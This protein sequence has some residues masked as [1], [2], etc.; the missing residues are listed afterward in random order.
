MD[1]RKIK[2]VVIVNDFNYVQGGASKVAIDTAKILKEQGIKVFFFSAVNKENEKINGVKY[3][4]TNQ[5]EALKEKNKIK[6]AIN[7]IYN[8]KAKKELKKLL[9]TL[10]RDNTIIHVHGWTKALSSSVFDIAFKMRF[11]VVLTLHDYFTACP[12][13]GYFNY[14]KN[15]ICK[16]KPLSWKC[17]KCNCDSRN[18][19]FKLYRLIR[20]FVQNKI[21][22]LND[23]LENVITISEFS[24]KIL[25]TTLGKN[26]RVTRIYNPIDIEKNLEKVD[27]SKNE[28]YLYV[29]R[30]SKEKGVDLFCQA[31]SELDYK[32]IVV[33]DGDERQKLE[34][35]FPNIEFTGWKNK[36]EVKQYMKGAKALIF[37][38]KW[39]E[40]APLTPLEA[41]QYG[42]PCICSNVS[43]AVDYS[44]DNILIF[45]LNKD[46]L[47]K[48]IVCYEKNIDKY[49]KESFEFVKSRINI[50]YGNEITNY[51]KKII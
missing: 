16:F 42:V 17:I 51:F 8:L 19:G 43:A 12:N 10:D 30:V 13:G 23:K 22:K 48:K 24:E 20:Q 36:D 34:T 28:Y 9:K 5:Q 31:I 33:G 47:K 11:K 15:E 25:K 29:G 21:V 3:I 4:S 7:G 32:G 26:T 35:E 14:K 46:E 50:D 37:P 45:E 27:P 41:M 40:G 1:D 38:S 18:Y 49:S 2:N 6:G 39:Y 44:I